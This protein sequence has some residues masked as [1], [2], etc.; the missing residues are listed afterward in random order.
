MEVAKSPLSARSARGGDLATEH[1]AAWIWY[2][3]S[4]P[5]RAFS[6][7]YFGWR[8]LVVVINGGMFHCLQWSTWDRFA[9]CSRSKKKWPLLATRQ[10]HAGP[11]YKRRKQELTTRSGKLKAELR[12]D[13][14]RNLIAFHR[15]T[16]M[17]FRLFAAIEKGLM[18]FVK[19]FERN[20]TLTAS[21]CAWSLLLSETRVNLELV[22]PPLCPRMC[23]ERR[24]EAE[25]KE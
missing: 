20:E 1:W 24:A 5:F 25:R 16:W 18:P 14:A 8:P 3:F 10:M 6:K 15:H 11:P 13:K 17:H 12:H 4:Q 22:R 7:P 9:L 21:L 23:N 2:F 19:D